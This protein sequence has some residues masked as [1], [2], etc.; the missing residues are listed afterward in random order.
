MTTMF[1]LHLLVHAFRKDLD[2]PDRPS[3]PAQHLQHYYSKYFSRSFSP[4]VFSF[5]K[6]ADFLEII[7]MVITENEETTLIVTELAEDTPPETFMKLAEDHRRD[8]S[9][10]VDAGYET[11][12]LKYTKPKGSGKGAPEKQGGGKSDGGKGGGKSEGKSGSKNKSDRNEKPNGKGSS[13]KSSSAIPRWGSGGGGAEKPSSSPIVPA[14]SEGKS[15]KGK[16]KGNDSRRDYNTS[17]PAKRPWS[18]S[19]APSSRP[20]PQRP[21]P[22][23]RS[24][25]Q[26]APRPSPT[27]S[28][29]AS[30]APQRSSEP[31]WKRA[32]P[33]NNSAMR[34]AGSFSRR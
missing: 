6:M 22:W 31:A 2:D 33:G 23:A 20:A 9:R 4:S 5:D 17:A 14:R 24:D 26:A 25:S 34:G 29:W 3:F 21:S 15:S 11:A 7:R 18:S 13:G 30:S 16:S 10:R 32:R 8:R 27:A 12:M 28:K 1:E 19:Q